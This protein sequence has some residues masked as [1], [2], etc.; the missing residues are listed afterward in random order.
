M[1]TKARLRRD[2][3][4]RLIL[5]GSVIFCLL[6]LWFCRHP[7]VWQSDEQSV[8]GTTI[9]LEAVSD[10]LIVVDYNKFKNSPDKFD[11]MDF[12]LAWINTLQQEIGPI[13]I[14]DAETFADADL[15]K[16]RSI[17]LTRSA[18]SIDAWTPKLRGFLERGG[19]LI[20]EMPEGAIRT[21]ASADGKGGLRSAQNITFATG[22]DE[23]LLKSFSALDLSSR[24]QIIG[25]AGPLEEADNYLYI[26]G[27][28]VIYAKN[29]ATG[30]VITVDF[31]YGML[32]TSLQQ[33]RPLDNFHIRNLYDSNKIETSDLSVSPENVSYEVPL[34]DLLERF[35]F[36]GVIDNVTPVTGFWPFFDGQ[37]G[38]MIVTHHEQGIGDLAVWMPEYEAT[39]KATSTLFVKA[40]PALTQT[41][42][43]ALKQYKTEIGLAISNTSSAAKPLGPLSFSPIWRKL[44]FAEQ[45]AALKTLLGDETPLLTSQSDAGLWTEQ[46]THGFRILAAAKF[47]ADASYKAPDDHPGYAFMTGM[48]FMPL[49]T[50][51]KIFNI[52]EFPIAYPKINND[53]DVERIQSALE[54]SK[55]AY[56]QCIG[57]T[58]EPNF[59]IQNPDLETFKAWKKLY[60]T[61]SDAG[62][63]VTGIQP[64]FRFSRARYNADLKSTTGSITINHKK[65][66]V[67][68][69]ETLAPESGMML[70]VPSKVGQKHFVEAR[71]GVHRVREDALLSETL[72]TKPVS[73]FGFERILVPAPKGF[74]AI[75]VVYE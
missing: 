47:N 67:L 19:T 20:L 37:M 40:P 44:N 54:L 31:N 26:D 28:P 18:A 53:E 45:T 3:I 10:Y 1:S 8:S 50:N 14:M 5:W 35:L 12:S 25:S 49:D 22:L 34:A 11:Q 15:T 65:T 36:Y 74:N 61:A 7:F 46:Y 30:H 57:V 6:L 60:R 48:P 62:H 75:D 68:R 58:F 63:W 32:L 55:S 56:H 42:L 73:I 4:T 39:F 24:T 2:R 21:I 41:G 52:L 70:S 38:A 9:K 43:D 59:F 16:Y 72:E 23:S 69:L 29:Y 33:G 64:F 17:I 51:G 71:R 13:N 66:F 27:V